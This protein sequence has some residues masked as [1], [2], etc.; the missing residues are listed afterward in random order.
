MTDSRA[1]TWLSLEPGG[2][3]DDGE[4]SRSQLGQTARQV[5]NLSEPNLGP[6]KE[7]NG[8]SMFRSILLMAASASC[9]IG[10]LLSSGWRE[11]GGIDADLGSACVAV[12]LSVRADFHL[13]SRAFC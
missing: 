10:P 9:V 1:G 4:A 12:R 5:K 6:E 2:D 7:N 13:V 3:S 8:L 11:G